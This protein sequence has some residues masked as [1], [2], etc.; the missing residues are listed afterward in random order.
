M[1]NACPNCGAVYAVTAKDI[2]RKIKCKKCSTALRVDDS[3]LVEDAPPP[4][5]SKASPALAAAVVDDDDEPVVTPKSKKTRQYSREGGGDGFLKKIGGIPTILFSAGVFL[6]LWF[7]F[8]TPI[9]QA[10]TKRAEAGLSQ[11]QMD[12]QAEI[13]KAKGDAEKIKKIQEDYA[14]KMETASEDATHAEVSNARSEYFE[15]YGQLFGFLLV[16]FGCIGYLRTE[17]PMVM[18]IVAGTILSLMMFVVFLLATAG[19]CGG[20]GPRMPTS[21]PPVGMKGLD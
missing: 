6:V 2:G 20:A 10:A 11:L 1:N 19:G 8:M 16:A 12:Q 4:P 9:G 21:R 13:K 14:K 7:T 5:P 17:Q 15:K 18:R 3:G